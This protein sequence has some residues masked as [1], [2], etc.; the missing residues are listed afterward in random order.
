MRPRHRVHPAVLKLLSPF[1]RFSYGR[2]AY[3]LR[4]VG[5]RLGPVLVRKD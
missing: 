1:F 5:N 3:V 4:L 2:G